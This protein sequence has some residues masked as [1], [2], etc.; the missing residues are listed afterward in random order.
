MRQ[1]VLAFVEGVP[2]AGDEEV[3]KEVARMLKD[4]LGRDARV[5]KAGCEGIYGDSDVVL[6][7][8]TGETPSGLRGL[9]VELYNSA[10]APFKE[11][12]VQAVYVDG[13]RVA[14]RYRRSGRL[15]CEVADMIARELGREAGRCSSSKTLFCCVVSGVKIVRCCLTRIFG[16]GR[17][18]R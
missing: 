10:V 2:V 17:P 5:V 15:S 1:V 18:T 8:I 12:D 7:I 4:L 11:P 9:Y 16:G 6:G 13:S 3:V 14:C